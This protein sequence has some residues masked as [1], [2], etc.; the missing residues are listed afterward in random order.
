M[1]KAIQQYNMIAM[2]TVGQRQQQEQL[3]KTTIQT[4][5][6]ESSV[7]LSERNSDSRSKTPSTLFLELDD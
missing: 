3:R 5:R 2:T 4:V 7:C 1:K 6:S